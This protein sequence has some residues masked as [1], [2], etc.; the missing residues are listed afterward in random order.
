MAF[1]PVGELSVETVYAHPPVDGEDRTILDRLI[2]L[3]EDTPA[4]GRIH[5]T[6]F[7]LNDVAVRDALLAAN[8][9]GVAVH[10]VHN[11]R[12]VADEV[13]ARLARDVPIGLGERH[14]WT[15]APFDPSGK[16]EDFG[17][18]ATGPDS[19]M[20]TKLFLFSSTRD[21][22]GDLRHHVCWWSSANLSQRSGTVKS[23]NTV[24]LY[25][26]AILYDAFR[27][28][29]WDLMWHAVHFPR[30]DFYD[31]SSGRG[32]FMGSPAS[33]T[34]VFCSP[35]QSSDLWIGRLGSVVV[36]PATEVHVA[37]ARFV[38]RRLVVADRLAEMA[39]Q[40]AAVRVLVATNPAFLGP[41]V[42]RR[43]LDAGIAL[44]TSNIHDK[45]VLVNA[46]HGVSTRARK[47]VLSGSHNLNYDANYRND[48][49]LVKTF[50]D[51][52]YDDM[53]TEHFEKIWASGSPVTHATPAY[54][55][56]DHPAVEATGGEMP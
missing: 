51:E 27:H 39:R 13:A 4:G 8:N 41:K 21:P 45:L 23:N 28:Q 53:L 34:K 26:D 25:G 40:G 1:F 17:A 30:N 37:Q 19:D 3:I 35:Q 33:K 6:I 24:V 20:H 31:S 42:R 50:N 2:R 29:L 32:M 12:D 14:R 18:I 48:E 38:D 16:V 55:E 56:D 7:R 44:R 22:H 36:D 11:G 52:L 47:V 54:G 15:G 10:V 5:A 9:R 43:L 46:R 49:I